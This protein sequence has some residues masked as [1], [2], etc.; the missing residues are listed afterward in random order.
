MRQ[1][2]CSLLLATCALA[3]WATPLLPTQDLPAD[4]GP[5][6]VR[7]YF[8][9]K[10]QLDRL[11][12]RM[13]P[14]EVN[15]AQHFVVIEVPDRAAYAGLLAEGFTVTPDPALTA[16]L[17]QPGRG[18]DS[19][20]GYACYRTV[21]ETFA[22]LV[23][24]VSANPTLASIVD[25]GDSWEKVR[26]PAN[27]YDMRVL[28]LSNSAIAGP[29]PRVFLMGAIHAREYATA[30]TLTRFAENL[31]ARYPTDADVRWM[32]DYHELYILPQANPDG[33]KKAEAGQLWRKNVN[34]TYCG[35][36]SSTRGADLNRN[37]PFEWGAHGGSSGVP[38]DETF[39]GAS[40]GS[41]P[42][43]TSVINY[44]RTIFPDVRP[45]DL[46]TPA[47]ADTSGIFLD[48][49]S[50]GQLVMWPWGFTNGIAPNGVGLT[51]LG[52]RTAY[53]ND[54]TPEQAIELYVTDGGTKDFVYGDLGI[55]TMSFEI[56]TAF[57]ESCAGFESTIWPD[58][59]NAL[60]YLLRVAR[61]P[62]QEP[63]GPSVTE[64]LSAPIEPGETISLIGA[65]SDARFKQ[66]NGAEPVQAV[67]GADVYLGTLPWSPGATPDALATPLDGSFNSSSEGLSFTLA[68][69][70]RPVGRYTAYVRARDSGAAGPVWAQHIDILASGSSARLQGAVR[71]ATTL[72]PVAVPAVLR[73]GPYGSASAPNLG[74]SYSMRAPN[75]SYALTVDAPGYAP[76]SLSNIVLTAPNTQ[77]L[78]VDLAPL[79]SLFEDNASAG[80]GNF[81]LQ[82][83]WNV[84]SNRFV[85]AP[86]AFTDSPSGTYANNTNVAMTSVPLDFRDTSGLRLRFQSWCDTEAGYD[87]GHVEVST[88]G[89]TW[90]ELW[91][92]NASAS[93]SAID[94]PLTAL[95]GSATARIRFRLS[96]D[97]SQVL[98][99]WS[100]DD[101]SIVGAGPACGAPADA[102]FANGFE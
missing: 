49:H 40:A 78:N 21:E 32:L 66:N 74:S 97:S 45:P 12:R 14:W 80:T 77:T 35:P 5:W 6:V 68:S 11:S 9:D 95:E 67:S 27:G 46:V 101:I 92:C 34:E 71:N 53:L 37:F 79:C 96:S 75:G 18:M 19:V 44:L 72:Q 69:G 50:Y 73:L 26:N 43:T 85:S 84:G 65:A 39:R 48:V 41:E 28:K 42:E 30:E 47:P 100:V 20:P 22:T 52:R 23:A 99:G 91:S 51:T 13:E 60:E 94:L 1:L 89:S 62:Y 58:N 70:A 93:W 2:L 102:V 25:I 38:C 88:N 64:L 59:R 33:R 90:S 76:K 86:Q 61:R 81:T 56:G 24:I 57:F 36:T 15:H 54:Y 55:A 10:A 4:N 31:I 87:Y 83:P 98:D 3:A 16:L 8:S 63:A 82:S 7:A 29:K 17:R